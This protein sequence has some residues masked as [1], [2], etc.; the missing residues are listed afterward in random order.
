LATTAGEVEEHALRIT[1][2]TG[3]QESISVR[4]KQPLKFNTEAFSSYLHA[5]LPYFIFSLSLLSLLL[6]FD[7]SCLFK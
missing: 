1:D 3:I 7:L 5:G 2:G 6:S 4:V